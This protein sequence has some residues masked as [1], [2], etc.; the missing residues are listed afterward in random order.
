MK[1]AKMDGAM[2]RW[3]DQAV[4]FMKQRGTLESVLLRMKNISMTG[5]LDQ[6]HEQTKLQA[7]V[8]ERVVMRMKNSALAGVSYR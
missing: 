6:W 1:N 2:D 7:S 3:H 8:L 4:L 5:A